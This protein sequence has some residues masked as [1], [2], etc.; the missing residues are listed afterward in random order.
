MP[1]VGLSTARVV[2]AAA[3]LADRNGFERL[4]LADLAAE[5]DVKVPSLYKHIDSLEDLRLR[6]AVLAADEIATALEV[7][8]VPRRGRVG[9]VAIANTYRQYALSHPGR[10]WALMR[11][12]IEV[13]EGEAIRRAMEPLWRCI[14]DYGVPE[15]EI[16]TV[17]LA[18]RAALRG[19]VLLEIAG[20]VGDDADEVYARLVSMLDRGLSLSRSGRVRGRRLGEL[21]MPGR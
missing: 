13:R 10:F 5:F 2:A 1:R 17:V 20:D 21:R 6:M 14:A 15:S 12:P 3:D 4:T 7:Q 11:A 19:H 18:V 16:E 8:H 9:L